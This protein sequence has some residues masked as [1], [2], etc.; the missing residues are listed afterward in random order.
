M[1]I[2]LRVFTKYVIFMELTAIVQ[3]IIAGDGTNGKYDDLIGHVAV[4]TVDN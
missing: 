2:L 4:D 1:D 3:I